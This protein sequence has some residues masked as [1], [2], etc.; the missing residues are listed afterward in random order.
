MSGVVPCWPCLL[1]WRR[2]GLRHVEYFVV[3]HIHVAVS[4]VR[5]VQCCGVMS[6]RESSVVQCCGVM[7]E[8]RV[9]CS[10]VE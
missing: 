5:V 2:Q 1:T 3:S 7:S 9:R 4:D 6:V 10:A 8:R